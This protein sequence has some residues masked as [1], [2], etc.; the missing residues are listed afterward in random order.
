MTDNDRPAPNACEDRGA[1]LYRRWLGGDE[2]AFDEILRANFDRLTFFLE[3]YVGDAASAEDIAMDVFAWIVA[4]PKRYNYSTSL[5]TYLFMLGR[6][7]ALNQIKRRDRTLAVPLEAAE[8]T[9]S[10]G[11]T[12][13]DAV[14]LTERNRELNAALDRLADDMRLAVHLVYFEEMSYGEAA[15]VMNKSKKQIDNLL[16]RARKELREALEAKGVTV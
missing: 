8:N 9:P 3:R 13:E 10:S 11:E 4:N 12:P 1:L 7:R 15:K 6:S 14:L 16:Y 5:K 2:S